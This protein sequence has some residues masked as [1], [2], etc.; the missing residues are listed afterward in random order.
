[1][2]LVKSIG[3]EVMVAGSD[4]VAVTDVLVGLAGFV[5]AHPVLTAVRAAAAQGELQGRGGD[6]FGAEVNLAARAVKLASPGQVVVTDPVADALAAAG[7][8]VTPL[9]P[10]AVRGVAG[11]VTLHLVGR[12]AGVNR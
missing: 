6:W 12:A 10:R 11:P 1:V 8:A 4:P 9:E 5:D 7:R 3:D 2:R